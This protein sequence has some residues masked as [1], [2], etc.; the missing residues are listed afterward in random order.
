MSAYGKFETVGEIAQ[1]SRTTVYSARAAAGAGKN[2]YAVKVFA[3]V[4]LPGQAINDR[5]GARKFAE[6]YEAQRLASGQRAKHWAPV[7]E[8]G[9]FPGG[10]FYATRRYPRS[11]DRLIDL[12]V[13]ITSESL[14]HVLLSLV[15]ALREIEKRAGRSHGNLK[16]SNVF[17]SEGQLLK[18]RIVV[19]DP[20]A[21]S[22]ISGPSAAAADLKALGTI[23]FRLVRQRDVRGEVG[24]PVTAS[25]DW[26]VLGARA[27]AW[28]ELCNQLLD[29][30]ALAKGLTL[31]DIERRLVQLR[32]RGAH[33]RVL[34]AAIGVPGLLLVGAFLYLRFA[35]YDSM[36]ERLADYAELV[37]N[38]PPDSAVPPE[39][40]KLLCDA[41]NDWLGSILAALKDPATREAWQRDPLLGPQVL[42]RLDDAADRKTVLDPRVI[43]GQDGNLEEFSARPPEIVKKG[44]MRLHIRRA[45]KNV[46]P[47]KTALESWSAPT[48]IASSGDRLAKL[49]WTAPA[50]ELK[51]ALARN[52][53]RALTAA[54][55]DDTLAERAKAERADAAYD[56]TVRHAEVLASTG[57]PFL[58]QLADFYRK[59]AARAGSVDE[60]DQ[61]LTA[62]NQ[63]L[64]NWVTFVHG[65]WASVDKSRL[66]R[67]GAVDRAPGPVTARRIADWKAEAAD[68]TLVSA[69]DDP[70][71][72]TDWPALAAS[73]QKS[74]EQYAL[75]ERGAPAARDPSLVPSSV[76][77]ERA[78]A[79]ADQ[80]AALNAAPVV[81]KDIAPTAARV[82]DLTAAHRAL[83]EQ[84]SA[85]LVLFHPDVADWIKG[86]AALVFPG[87]PSLERAWQERSRLLLGNATARELAGDQTR[88]RD[89]RIAA[90]SLKGLLRDLS[91][92][93]ALAPAALPAGDIPADIRSQ[94]DAWLAAQRETALGAIVRS[95]DWAG[96]QRG[97]DA[98]AVLATPA[99][100]AARTAYADALRSATDL[101]SDSG[102]IRAD[103]ALGRGLDEGAGAAAQRAEGRPAAAALIHTGALGQVTASVEELR[104]LA[105]STDAAALAV[106][107]AAGPLAG[108]LGAWRRLGGLGAWPGS[109]AELDREGEAE[110]GLA[111]RLAQ[112]DPDAARQARLKDEFAREAKARW[113]KALRAS[114]GVGAPEVAAVFGKMGAFGV[115]LDSL[116]DAAR[117]DLDL[118]Q[119]KA[120]AAAAR[121]TQDADDARSRFGDRVKAL[122]SLSGHADVAAFQGAIQG[123]SL[124]KGDPAADVRGM[125]P[126]QAGWSAEPATSSSQVTY[127]WTSAAGQAYALTFD[128][129]ELADNDPYFLCT[130]DMPIGLFLEILSQN[131]AD[132]F[133][134]TE[135]PSW[136]ASVQSPAEDQRQGPRVWTVDYRRAGHLRLSDQWTGVRMP[137][138]PDQVYAPGEKI[139]PP[140][141]LSP[142]QYIDPAAAR[143]FAEH[144]LHCRLPT[145][146]EWSETL[147]ALGGPRLK[148][149][150]WNLRDRTW[151]LQQAYLAKSGSSFDLPWPDS[152]IFIPASLGTIRR[153]GD[154]VSANDG[155]DGTLWF[156]D[157]DTPAGSLPFSHLIGNVAIVLWNPKTASYAVS[158]GS[159]LSP[160]EVDPTAIY[161]VD[162]Q[163][164]R[165]GYSDVGFRPAFN[166]PDSLVG[167][168][169]LSR[170]IRDQG[171]LR[172]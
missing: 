22:D 77:Q 23:L 99:G 168:S 74:L 9:D 103:L 119:L 101:A 57:D 153:A 157:V 156:A 95:I 98:Q 172:L 97:A 31:D 92:P 158:G 91:A 111:A 50:A 146:S 141:R 133:V 1:N 42:A 123:V 121:T 62:A 84:I 55:I 134:A 104:S 89:L 69:A 70:R 73:L 143:I 166:A 126:A 154:A 39:E 110:K 76:L 59:P 43:I 5:T 7:L 115:T 167:K 32:F 29:P 49:G 114:A 37:G 151:Q 54:G 136:I 14:R 149:L 45:W 120:E 87:S 94:I 144:Y 28:R 129:V 132:T 56:Q 82:R 47:I 58:G 100:G 51:A 52:Q 96:V 161:A 36:P 24:W 160:A 152:D 17:I 130:T 2:G 128:L 48:A 171:F 25:P 64:S 11:L 138:W 46:L 108:S 30:Q 85:S 72:S 163:Q 88:F 10:A 112:A 80:V 21:A 78:R 6:A 41:Y 145:P 116:D 162:S 26:D 127:R 19:A 107:A 35:P 86:L 16:A 3:P 118:S 4:S 105:A 20:L 68:Y 93:Q 34:F 40:W 15:R 81:R 33:K 71:Q 13:K 83:A 117:Y 75:E 131:P 106:R 66:A 164:E 137:T 53:A 18:A 109:P 169:R 63:N 155:D 139:G 8:A 125:G 150:R 65:P 113:R 148:A 67:E 90:E 159:A 170:L 147:A 124:A 122:A 44:V 142:V 135:M 12:R 61:A 38:V 102:E 140:T 79:L 27:E 165:E 60:L